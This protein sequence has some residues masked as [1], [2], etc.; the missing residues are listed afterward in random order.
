MRIGYHFG[1]GFWVPARTN[2]SNLTPRSDAP[3][4]QGEPQSEPQSGSG[5]PGFCREE[6]R[7]TR[8]SDPT[9]GACGG[10]A[11][12]ARA[13]RD[14][15][16]THIC[17]ERVARGYRPLKRVGSGRREQTEV[18]TFGSRDVAVVGSSSKRSPS[19]VAGSTRET[20]LNMA[21]RGLIG[22]PSQRHKSVEEYA[23]ERRALIAAGDHLGLQELPRDPSRTRVANRCQATG[24]RCDSPRAFGV[25]PHRVPGDGTRWVLA[26]GQ[27]GELVSGVAAGSPRRRCARVS[28]W[29]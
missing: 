23:D 26:G 25:S 8:R 5:I 4:D 12:A 24:R 21:R 2:R 1:W 7:D 10:S 16:S 11:R 6:N 17:A 13:V 22:K 27:E 20:E 3:R 18:T 29:G 15:R 9:R 19:L 14:P 28:S